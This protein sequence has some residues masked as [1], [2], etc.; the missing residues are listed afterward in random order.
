MRSPPTSPKGGGAGAA[1]ANTV[2]VAQGSKQPDPA[3]LQAVELARQGGG[4]K[5]PPVCESGADALRWCK[6]AAEKTVVGN[7]VEQGLPEAKKFLP[8][9]KQRL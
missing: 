3:V 6:L 7:D 1:G 4:K 5:P 9:L 2:V 8:K